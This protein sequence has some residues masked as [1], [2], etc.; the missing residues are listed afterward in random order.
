MVAAKSSS[1]TGVPAGLLDSLAAA[2]ALGDIELVESLPVGYSSDVYLVRAGGRRLV[3][4]LQKLRAGVESLAW[5]H[6][7]LAALAELLPAV[8]SPLRTSDGATFLVDDARALSLLPYVGGRPARVDHPGDRAEAARLLGRL[9]A[10][11]GAL[12]LPTR[13]AHPRLRDLPFPEVGA[14]PPNI[15]RT[16][17]S[18]LR[19]QAVEAVRTLSARRLTTGLVHGDYFPAN[20]LVRNHRAA[21]LLDWE[22]ADV[23]WQAYELACAAWS[24]TVPET[25]DELDREA[26][27]DFVGRYRD[28][29][30]TVPSQEDDVLVQLVRVKRILE[31]LRAPS[32]RR[33]D[34][35]YQ[36]Q[37]VR[38]AE[39]LA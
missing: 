1:V 32:D 12:A 27:A 26:F 14:Y 2:Y 28:A 6:A 4:R 34:S 25:R 17:V 36:L 29:G 38:A 35:D 31:V 23:D 13:P 39:K 16:R 7:L 11:S 33:V 3:L 8:S 24:F 10:A 18:E 19:G 5:E 22:E 20:V 21:G 30:G 9:H 15:A 37:N